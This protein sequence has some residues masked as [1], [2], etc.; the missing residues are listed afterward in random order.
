MKKYNYG[1]MFTEGVESPSVDG[2][3]SK[4]NNCINKYADSG[5]TVFDVSMQSLLT[6]GISTIP[7]K[8]YALITFIKKD[9][10]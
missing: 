2:L 10:K 1:Q 4:I 8:H 3:S 7:I 9:N 6:K 5:Y